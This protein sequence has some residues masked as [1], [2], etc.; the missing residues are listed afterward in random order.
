MDNNKVSGIKFPRNQYVLRLMDVE[1]KVSQ[2][3]KPMLV[4]DWEVAS[5]N[6]I[7]TIQGV[8]V[9]AGQK[10]RNYAM[11]DEQGLKYTQQFL[12]KVQVVIEDLSR[13]NVDNDQQFNLTPL[14][15]IQVK[16]ICQSKVET[17]MGTEVDE[18]GKEIAI[19][20][21]NDDGNPLTAWKFEFALRDI[22]VKVD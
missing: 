20:L 9:V 14:K 4:L 5:P 11:L 12:D 2:K 8:Q 19:T 13:Q 22:V 1:Q 7:K 21:K 17:Q 10:C 18:E 3:G 16:A 15:G 6:E